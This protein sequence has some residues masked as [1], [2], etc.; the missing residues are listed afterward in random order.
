MQANF[1]TILYEYNEGISPSELLIMEF[2]RRTTFKIRMKKTP[3]S[4][5]ILFSGKSGGNS[6]VGPIGN[7]I[8]NLWTHRV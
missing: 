7:P 5:I 2:F 8:L 4:K 3:L 6:Q 1:L